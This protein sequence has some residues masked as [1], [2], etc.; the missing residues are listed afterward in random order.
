MIAAMKLLFLCSAIFLA[1]FIDSIAGGGGLISL[2]SYNV[3]G[4]TGQDSLGTNK[5]SSFIGGI[6]ACANYIKTKNY[7][8]PSLISAF[9]GALAGSA[10]GSNLALSVNKDVFNIIMLV[11]TP[12]VA[13]ITFIKK[14]FSNRE[15]KPMSRAM[16]IIFG[17]L[18]GIVVGFYDG[19][20]GPGAGMFMQLGFIMICK[21]EPI[22][23]AGNARMVNAASNLAAL[24]TF[25][26]SG[27]VV[28]AVAIPCACCSIIGNI[29]GSRMAI[30]KDVKI[31]RPV[32][33]IVVS[34]LFAKILLDF[35]GVKF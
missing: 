32:M 7:H 13:V 9:L 18:I 25:M 14:D 27:N 11:A 15:A 4:I 35:L 1:A 3:A 17:A 21:L 6:L 28:Y 26:I 31:I 8:L 19:F 34:L 2:N 29:V 30:K 22:K 23:A 16:Y 33:F 12:I 24:I 5:F 10:A 20:Y